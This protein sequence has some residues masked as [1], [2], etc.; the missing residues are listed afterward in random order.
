[1][2]FVLHWKM[3]RYSQLHTKTLRPV[4]RRSI[5]VS[6]DLH[7]VNNKGHG[8]AA[9]AQNAEVLAVLYANGANLTLCD[10]KCRS[11]LFYFAFFGRVDCIAFLLNMYG[12]SNLA[13]VRDIN[14][15]TPMHAAW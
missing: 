10:T 6:Q 7:V 12:T 4:L 2:P 1:M 14:G 13:D 11:C 9:V 15:D 8:P 5:L 3:S